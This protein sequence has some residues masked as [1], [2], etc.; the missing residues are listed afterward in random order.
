M[1]HTTSK[2]LW[3][4]T[5]LVTMSVANAFADNVAKIGATEYE[6]LQAAIN[7]VPANTETTI[8]LIG[9]D[10]AV[11]GNGF[12]I[13]DGTTGKNI[14]IDFNGCTYTVTGGAV[15]SKGTIN[16]C[17]HFYKDNTLTLKNGTIK[18]QEN[19]AGVKIM[20]QNYCDLTLDNFN[21][22]CSNVIT[23]TYAG[24][25]GNDA[26]WNG[27]TRPKFNFNSGTSNITNSTITFSN[28]D[29][30]GVL[31]DL[32]G[33]SAANLTIGEGTTINGNVTAL[34][35]NATINAGTITGN[36][37]TD[38]V[39]ADQAAGS[40]IING[41]TVAG[42]TTAAYG[43]ITTSVETP[44]QLKAA[45]EGLEDDNH[46]IKL[47][48]TIK[49]EANIA[50]SHSFTLDFGSYSITK[51][52][53]SIA[54]ADE[55]TV[56]TSAN[57]ASTARG[58][59]Y[60]T[61][62][63]SWE[64]CRKK[65]NDTSYSFT[66]A[67]PE[68]KFTGGYFA[69]LKDAVEDAYYTSIT[70]LKNVTMEDDIY[71]AVNRKG[72]TLILSL[73]NYTLNNGGH[74]IYM[75]KDVTAKLDKE[76]ENSSFASYDGEVGNL[77]TYEG[78]GTNKYCYVF[79]NENEAKIGET[80]YATFALATASAGENDVITLLR[81]VLEPYTMTTSSQT[82][83]V[84]KDGYSITV[85]GYEEF[86]AKSST[87]DGITTYTQTPAAVKITNADNSVSYSE[88]LSLLQ[89]NGSTLTLL[90]DYSTTSWLNFTNVYSDRSITLDLGGHTLSVNTSAKGRNYCII[91]NYNSTLTV[92]N[93]IIEMTPTSV[94]KSNGIYVDDACSLIVEPTATIRAH[95][96]SAVTVW[97]TATLETEGT[98]YAENDFVIAGN[99]GNGNGGYS[100]NIAGGSVTSDGQP[101]IYHPNTG[102]VTISD[103]E[104][105][106][107]TAIYQKCGTLNI[108]G[109]TITGNGTKT[110]FV[111]N[112]NGANATGDAVV[113]ENCGYPGGTPVP[114]IT[115]GTFT[116]T[117]AKAVASYAWGSDRKPVTGII[118]GGTYSSNVNDLVAEGKMAVQDVQENN[119]YKVYAVETNTTV[120]TAEVQQTM[121]V[122]DGEVTK[123]TITISVTPTSEQSVTA[124]GE[125]AL[126]Q[127]DITSVIGNIIETADFGTAEQVSVTV[128]LQ[129]NA[130][131]T[132]S[133]LADDT[134]TITFEVKPE[135]VVKINNQAATAVELSN[136]NLAPNAT[137]TFTLDV[138]AMGLNAGDQ[139]K[140]VHKSIDPNY[141]YETFMATVWA[142][143]DKQ[144]VT[145]T[146]THFSEFEITNE[147]ISANDD[148]TLIDGAVDYNITSEV[149]VKS[150]T[151]ERTFPETQVNKFM[152]WFVP[153]DYTVTED[154]AARAKF[155]KIDMIAHSATQGTTDQVDESK[156][157][158]HL[159]E[160]TAGTTLKGN[161]PYLIK[162][163]ISGKFT[164]E[165][166]NKLLA[167]TN[168]SILSASTTSNEYN[169]YGTYSVFTKA[170]ESDAD[171][172][173]MKGGQIHW[174]TITGI[175]VPAFRWIIK[176]NGKAD[177]ARI[178]FTEDGEETTA[179]QNAE[180]AEP[181]AIEGYYTLNGVKVEKPGKGVYVVK[182]ANG[183]VSK[184]RIR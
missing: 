115:G 29:L 25:T 8:T 42:N 72:G 48:K 83:K 175:T 70:F 36:V 4:L 112:G 63:T 168:E 18:V 20:M 179:I 95:G 39:E 145:I 53:Y 26:V 89:A 155:Y 50:A 9:Q 35:G 87:A 2:K 38:K 16:Q 128:E 81:N 19:L 183:Q 21:V 7:A 182:Y 80:E 64:I 136:N 24:Y 104:I 90:K 46:I 119:T 158:I 69:T 176:V 166:N 110:D 6:T 78:T 3:L 60:S 180:V 33:G 94:D 56:S 184:I 163:L 144:Y 55:A 160:V 88:S 174:C 123:Q 43:T 86:V 31:I 67:E 44:A 96:V 171:F 134:K 99:G 156:I 114:S 61:S 150:A 149:T 74:K 91:L 40:I 107:A 28:D 161:K 98:L 66:P 172:M 79:R 84:K 27:K 111:H 165:G 147:A 126:E 132:S 127:V 152:G 49:L 93:G 173:Y 137:F 97:G 65:T 118:S 106:G 116:S 178:A 45:I 167:M 22:D 59:I 100:V 125:V 162:P 85:V 169:F 130:D 124:E 117:N 153:F 170:E 113:I 13:P 5:L 122:K 47:T 17:M 73:G 103:G 146:T 139:V 10:A 159:K 157:W 92:K 141:Q 121:T 41:G 71:F 105:T 151:Y 181:S 133:D 51:G 23:Q 77:Y 75:H 131:V 120:N 148:I 82:L 34:G 177:Y 57:S 11:S 108:T 32:E 30:F 143:D 15:G 164:F 142:K 37:S 52:S 140:V 154:D 68:V 1:L 138:T 101:A 58:N 109:G 62:H 14:I 102:T 76:T 12:Q 135:A 54:L 129:V